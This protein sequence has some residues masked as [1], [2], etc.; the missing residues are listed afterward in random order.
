[1][2]A[3]FLWLLSM[4]LAQTI[5]WALLPVSLHPLLLSGLFDWRYSKAGL[6]DNVEVLLSS[7]CCYLQPN[8]AV[9]WTASTLRVPAASDFLRWAQP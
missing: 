3:A 8:P 9:H 5:G 6:R 1:M 7:Q 4:Q 2:G